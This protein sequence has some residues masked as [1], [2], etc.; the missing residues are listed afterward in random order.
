[1]HYKSRIINTKIN[2]IFEVLDQKQKEIEKE[3]SQYGKETQAL[4]RFILGVGPITAASFIS[5]IVS[6]NRFPSPKHLA[7]YCGIDPQST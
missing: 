7:A 2:T 3:L 4:L 5:K 1:M 6:I